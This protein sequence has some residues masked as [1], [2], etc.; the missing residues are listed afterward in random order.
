MTADEF[1]EAMDNDKAFQSKRKALV[2]VSLL[3]LALVVSGA[4]IKEANTFIFK[5]EFSNHVGLRY[6]LVVSVVACMLRYYSY[7]EKY[8]N[9][10]FVIWSGKLLA[11]SGVYYLDQEIGAV[12]GVL[13]GRLGVVFNGSYD[14]DNPV[15][16]K[17]WAVLKG[18]RL[19]YFNDARF[20]WRG[21]H[22]KVF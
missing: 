1:R 10:L 22:H 15:Y 17:N 4:Q 7:A 3:L 18:D 21:L 14:L 13:G 19:P 20:L 12:T 9:Q 6:L 8:R 16:K 2:F 5:I 11:D